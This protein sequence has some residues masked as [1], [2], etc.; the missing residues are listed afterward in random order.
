[1][2]KAKQN[3]HTIKTQQN[4]ERKPDDEAL[5][6]PG[7][8]KQEEPSNE[9]ILS[10]IEHKKDVIPI[11]EIHQMIEQRLTEHFTLEDCAQL[12]ELK[13]RT[14]KYQT[15]KPP[16]THLF[17]G[18]WRIVKGELIIDFNSVIQIYE[19]TPPPMLSQEQSELEPKEQKEEQD[20]PLPH[21]DKILRERDYVPSPDEEIKIHPPMLDDRKEEGNNE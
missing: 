8:M 16:N 9:T 5:P 10:P 14:F 12:V 13:S 17:K 21:P 4:V 20:E 3:F 7:T 2:T 6:V 19:D 11:N 1:M 15:G 18:K